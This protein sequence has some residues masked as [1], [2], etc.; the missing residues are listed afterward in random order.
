MTVEGLHNYL[1]RP[2]TIEIA[3]MLVRSR[4]PTILSHTGEILPA[5]T[6]I[7]ARLRPEHLTML[8]PLQA[9]ILNEQL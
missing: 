9:L 3:P 5:I 4:H 8:A 2:W 1:T 6:M 7:V